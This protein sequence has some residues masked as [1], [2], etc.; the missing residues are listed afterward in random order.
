MRA[1]KLLALAVLGAALTAFTA[2][3]ASATGYDSEDEPIDVSD[4]TPAPGGTVRIQAGGFDPY[5]QVTIT[6]HSEPVVLAT[7]TA[8]GEGY[9]DVTVTLPANVAVGAHEIQIAGT[10]PSGAPRTITRAITV[11]A[12]GSGSMPTTGAAIATL[13]T[14]AVTLLATGT[15][16]SRARRRALS[17]S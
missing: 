5:S 16:L 9:I 11:V 8:D 12:G 13:T 17:T 7:T 10:D 3:A 2:S 14:V 4:P 6:L 1:R 15:L